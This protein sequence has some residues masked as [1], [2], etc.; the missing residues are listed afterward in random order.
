VGVKMSLFNSLKKRLT[1]QFLAVIVYEDRCNIKQKVVKNSKL[2]HKEEFNFD[3]PSKDNLGGKVI[4]FINSL[5]DDYDNTYIALFLNTLGQGIIPN[6]DE[7][8]LEKFNVDH[9]NVKS[10]CKENRFLMYATL[11]DIK[12][13][14]KVFDKSGLDFVFSPFLVLDYF[15]KKAMKKESYSK[16]EVV[17]YMLNTNNALTLMIQ[18]GDKFLYGAFF[19][20]AKGEDLLYTNYDDVEDSEDQIEELNLDDISDLEMDDILDVS[21]QSNFV[22]NILQ[23]GE[24]ISEEDERIIKYLSSSLKEFYSN[25]LYHSEFI[26]AA[27]I[28]DDVGL[29]E[30]ILKYI[31]SELLLDTVA[32]NISVNDVIL[33]LSMQEASI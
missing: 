10:I 15:M 30:S 22:T 14:D 5:Q 20:I 1:N 33:D 27:K 11:I 8:A 12:W 32:E 13:A 31:E 29:N 21:N 16:E 18:K 23:S 9:K 2:L 25:E 6:C 19:N 24:N 17:L 26:T 28:Y 3:I 7:N 4:N